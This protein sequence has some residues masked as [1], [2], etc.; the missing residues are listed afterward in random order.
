MIKSNCCC[1]KGPERAPGPIP[2]LGDLP[3]TPQLGF[4]LDIE[5]GLLLLTSRLISTKWFFLS[6]SES[7]N[8]TYSYPTK[9]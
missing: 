7:N 2:W 4:E 8:E 6:T 3:K 9:Y 1:P 5:P